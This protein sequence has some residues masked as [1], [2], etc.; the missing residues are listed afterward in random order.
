MDQR[1][2][3][4]QGDITQ[5]NVDAIV[6]AANNQ[7]SHGGGVCGAIH[8]AAGPDL[9]KEC[10]KFDGCATGDAK[11]TKGYDLPASYVIHTVGPV[12]KGGDRNEPQ[13]LASTYYN[14]LKQANEVQANTVAFPAISC[15]IFGY[16]VEKA[17]EVAVK[18]V[19]DFLRQNALP[20][21]VYFVCFSKQDKACF[22]K[23]LADLLS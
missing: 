8:N 15:G 18:T 23:A 17:A 10:L 3:V 6:N 2:E 9:E 16:P 4:I 14:A 22:D 21:K 1:I 5:I 19:H 7:L 13:L 12:W 11:V 20:S